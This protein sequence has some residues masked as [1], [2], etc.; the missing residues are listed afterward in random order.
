MKLGIVG[1]PNVGK[2]TLFNAITN[3]GAQSAGLNP[4]DVIRRVKGRMSIVH[5][6]DYKIIGGAVQVEDVV[7][8]FG[9]VGEGNL[10][11]PAIV[12]ASRDIGVEYAI[13]EQDICPGDPFDSLKKSWDNL[14]KFGV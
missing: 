10:D 7:K 14:E 3:A 5:Y 9:E 4:P 11:W 13:V 12:Q 8:M 6:K 1:L 2:S